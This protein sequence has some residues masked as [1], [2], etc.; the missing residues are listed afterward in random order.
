MHS[1][2]AT[3]VWLGAATIELKGLETYSNERI[4][5]A[6]ARPEFAFVASVVM[7]LVIIVLRFAKNR[8]G[9][10]SYTFAASETLLTAS[11]S[12]GEAPC[13]V[14]KSTAARGQK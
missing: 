10:A 4:S 2:L 13:V 1:C 12:C 5:D 7:P 6:C 8:A 9:S 14:A 11:P 3:D